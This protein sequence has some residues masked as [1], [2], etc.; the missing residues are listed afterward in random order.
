MDDLMTASEH[1]AE[2]DRLDCIKKELEDERE[3]FTHAAVKLGKEKSAFEVTLFN[4]LS[5]TWSLIFMF[6]VNVSSSWKKGDHGRSNKCSL[7]TLQP[8][9]RKHCHPT[10][11]LPRVWLLTFPR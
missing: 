3:K 6:R 10:Y 2:R 9:L 4:V 1:D 7:N 8:L 11:L 5:S